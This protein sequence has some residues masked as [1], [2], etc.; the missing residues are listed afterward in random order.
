MPVGDVPAGPSWSKHLQALSWVGGPLS[1]RKAPSLAVPGVAAPCN[2]ACLPVQGATWAWATRYPGT[3]TGRPGTS[4]PAAGQLSLKVSTTKAVNE[5]KAVFEPQCL[6]C[7][8]GVVRVDRTAGTSCNANKQT[9]PT[10][11]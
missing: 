5:K 4:A 1:A 6:H 2:Y 9:Y 10:G 11:K 3:R 8:G 7:S